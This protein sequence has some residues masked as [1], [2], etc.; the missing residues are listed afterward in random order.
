MDFD[1][2]PLFDSLNKI[3]VNN[4]QPAMYYLSYMSI[5]ILSRIIM[6]F[7]Q[8]GHKTWNPGKTK[9][10]DQKSLKNMEF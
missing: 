1:S 6:I 10:F 7:Y 3:G 2:I 4:L 8:G 9:N 5:N